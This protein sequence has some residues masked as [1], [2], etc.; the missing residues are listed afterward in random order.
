[1]LDPSDSLITGAAVHVAQPPA[2]APAGAPK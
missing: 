2:A 1:V